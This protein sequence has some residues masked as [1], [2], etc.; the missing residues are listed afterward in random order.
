MAKTAE[1]DVGDVF[2][3]ARTCSILHRSYFSDVNGVSKIW[4]ELGREVILLGDSLTALCNND[5]V[6]PLDMDPQ[7]ESLQTA[8][9]IIGDFRETLNKLHDFLKRTNGFQSTGIPD[10]EIRW[11]T[12]LRIMEQV[13]ERIAIHSRAIDLTMT[14]AML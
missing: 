5:I 9:M 4:E 6:F 7:E 12:E 2:K 13:K 10:P 3:F 14:N 1:F 8:R 11:N